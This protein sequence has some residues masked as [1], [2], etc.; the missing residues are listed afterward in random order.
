MNKNTYILFLTIQ[1]VPF[2][3]VIG[4][5]AN[6][7]FRSFSQ[8]LYM[9]SFWLKRV[10]R[11]KMKRIAI[12]HWRLEFVYQVQW[13]WNF[14]KTLK[15]YKRTFF[16]LKMIFYNF[17]LINCFEFFLFLIVTSFSI[18]FSLY[19]FNCF[20]IFLSILI[21]SPE[22]NTHF[23]SQLLSDK[24]DIKTKKN[25]SD[26]LIRKLKFTKWFLNLIYFFFI[27]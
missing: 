11:N 18:S 13:K 5:S 26:Y 14:E 23:Q 19:F 8:R 15:I 3:K 27:D 12:C 17:A 22:Q 1:K 6:V 10:K 7:A 21:T 24:S 20:L 16:F 2:N 9:V 4:S 25:N